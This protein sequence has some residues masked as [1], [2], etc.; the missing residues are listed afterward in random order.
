MLTIVN[1]VSMIRVKV[2]S[3]KGTDITQFRSHDEGGVAAE[4]WGAACMEGWTSRLLCPS[5]PGACHP[6]I[7]IS[8]I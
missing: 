5:L 4:L 7:C 8:Q 3:L 2:L 1:N 6:H